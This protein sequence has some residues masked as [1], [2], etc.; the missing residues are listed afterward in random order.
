MSARTYL[1]AIDGRIGPEIGES[2]A[3]YRVSVA[4]GRTIISGPTL[5]QAALPTV[6]QR[7]SAL[8]LSLLTVTSSSITA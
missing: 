1:V 7:L 6:L 8:G 5:D 2:L 3:P 4:D